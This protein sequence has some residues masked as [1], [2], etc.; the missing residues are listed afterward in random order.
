MVATLADRY[1]DVDIVVDHMMFPD[2]TTAPDESPWTDFEELAERRNVAV[3]VSSLPRS[4][5]T[6]WPYKD[7]HGYVLRFV[8]WFGPERCILGSDW[9][10]DG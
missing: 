6:A 9:P 7:L 1:P 2:E 4:A 5:E 10:L 8:E 3:K